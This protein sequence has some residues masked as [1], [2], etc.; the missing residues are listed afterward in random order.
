MT[1]YNSQKKNKFPVIN[2]DGEIT[3]RFFILKLVDLWWIYGGFMV[4]LWWI[5]DIFMVDLW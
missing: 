3:G 5:C 1:Y 4:D 2:M